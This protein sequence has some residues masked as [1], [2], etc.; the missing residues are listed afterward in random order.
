MSI[1]SIMIVLFYFCVA[2][3]LVGRD[4]KKNALPHTD[5]LPEGFCP[6]AAHYL[7]TLGDIKFS[8]A[9]ALLSMAVK[10]YLI[11]EE[12]RIGMFCLRHTGKR[13]AILSPAEQAVA[14]QL[15][16]HEG[17]YFSLTRGK[18]VLF[19]KAEKALKRCLRAQLQDR[20]FHSNTGVFGIG[21]LLSIG[22]FV[23]QFPFYATSSDPFMVMLSTAGVA[24]F[25]YAGALGLL[26]LY[27]EIKSSGVPDLLSLFFVGSALVLL[28]FYGDLLG[29]MTASVTMAALALINAIFYDLL[30]A[31]TLKGRE[32]L[33]QLEG[34]RLFLEGRQGESVDLRSSLKANI[35]H[36]ERY[37]PY[38]IVL[39]R[40]E[41]WTRRC[42][43]ALSRARKAPKKVLRWYLGDRAWNELGYSF[44]YCFYTAVR[45][46]STPP[47]PRS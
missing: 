11:V 38:A 2:W 42:T 9:A 14:K 30:K 37:L 18:W 16:P 26:G 21:A 32:I 36:F 39:G 12:R 28:Y 3:Y 35:Q 22:L 19:R 23:W 47:T 31:P 43:S 5:K 40:E 45:I 27:K 44:S 33:D 29:T 10:G 46:A 34:L 13:N 6:A 7:W 17:A 25:T 24:A 8:V 4:P 41:V 20:Y 1:I 15:F